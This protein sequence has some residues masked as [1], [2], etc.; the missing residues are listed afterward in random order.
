M[1]IESEFE[2]AAPV[3]RVWDYFQ[4]VPALA[5]CL[6]GAELTEVLGEDSYRGQVVSKVGPVS[7]KFGG[8]AEVKERDAV[9]KRIVIQANGAE[10]K[11]K[12]TAAMN[13]TAHLVPAPRGTRVKVKQDLQLT[14]AVAQFG[15]GMVADVMTVI[16]RSF[17]GCVEENI[18]RAE[19]GESPTASARSA[20]GIGIAVSAAT[21]ALKRVF[22][23]LLGIRAWYE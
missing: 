19:R 2:V 10:A 6:P 16:M 7:L 9:N 18:R 20:G 5:P 22:G 23:R 13:I 17:A 11:G 14:G 1:L 12:G 4:D 3:D 8:T 21:L 15:R